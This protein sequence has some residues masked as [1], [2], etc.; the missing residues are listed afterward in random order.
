MSQYNQ[1]FSP[2][3]NGRCQNK[4]LNNSKHCEL[5][6]AKATKL[7]VKYKKLSNLAKNVDIHKKFDNT[8]DSVNHI[9]SCYV[10]YNKTYDARL[11]HR[12]YAIAPNLYD[13]GHDF[14]F[15]D[16]IN[17]I[18][19]CEEILNDLYNKLSLETN[20]VVY[21]EYSED[22]DKEDNEIIRKEITLAEKIQSNKEYRAKKEQEIN[23]YVE[24]YIDENK[25]II[26]RKCRLIYNLCKCISLVFGE[27]ED[28]VE[29]PKIIAIMSL[30]IKLDNISYFKEKFTPRGCKYPTCTC[31]LPYLLS[32]GTEHFHEPKCFCEYMETYSE[33]SLKYIF[34]IFLFNK[35]KISPFVSDINELYEEYDR[36]I[37]FINAELI[38][39]NKR[40]NLR[41][42]MS[43]REQIKMPSKILATS[44][45]KNKYYEQELLKNLFN[46]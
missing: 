42:D 21:M 29:R 18:N 39:K 34:E 24:K 30:I 28:L 40:L 2:A 15:T 5:H 31:T 35:K 33:E 9:H 36:G 19:Q 11:K 20:N 16:L 1:C 4:S 38:W 6:H 27:E 45:L 44:R 3:F 37:I 23:E 32:L 22:E 8:I 46:S 43:D 17:K 13:Q 7:Y 41:E 25:I 10:L 26:D 14:Q 12:E